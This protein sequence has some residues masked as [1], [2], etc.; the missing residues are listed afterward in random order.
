MHCFDNELNE[1]MHHYIVQ[2]QHEMEILGLAVRQFSH[3][4]AQGE[5]NSWHYFLIVKSSVDYW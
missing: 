3:S 2:L 5:G 4:L 1:R